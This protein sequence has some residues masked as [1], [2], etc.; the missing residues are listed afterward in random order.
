MSWRR[1]DLSSPSPQRRAKTRRTC[2]HAAAA[3]K[4][5]NLAAA[6]PILLI[7]TCSAARAITAVNAIG[8]VLSSFTTNTTTL[9]TA[10]YKIRV[11]GKAHAS[12]AG[13]PPACRQGGPDR[14]HPSPEAAPGFS[15]GFCPVSKPS[16]DSKWKNQALQRH[17]HSLAQLFLE[18]PKGTAKHPPPGSRL[19]HGAFRWPPRPPHAPL[20]SSKGPYF[21]QESLRW[22]FPALCRGS[23]VWEPTIKFG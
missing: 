20:S 10:V 4:R 17:S 21:T 14:Q 18:I 3:T 9:C 12:T 7:D 15:M 1:L 8:F 19:Q 16:L 23:T 5:T 22:R 13:T 2:M 11:V 6:P